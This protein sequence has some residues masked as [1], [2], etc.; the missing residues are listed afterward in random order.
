M[1]KLSNYTH[2]RY[3]TD[4]ADLTHGIEEVKDA[5]SI[6]IVNSEK[7]PYYYY[8]RLSKLKSKLERIQDI[9]QT[10]LSHY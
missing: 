4:R 2:A 3:C 6:R 5:I 7:I 8:V 9:T 1:K 10:Q